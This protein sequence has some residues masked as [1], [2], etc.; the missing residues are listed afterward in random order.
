MNRARGG[1]GAVKKACMEEVGEDG[2]VVYSMRVTVTS[3]QF[4]T[5]EVASSSVTLRLR[6]EGGVEEVEEV[7]ATVTLPGPRAM[8]EVRLRRKRG[9][10]GAL[11]EAKRS[12]EED[13]GRH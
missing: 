7:E 13:E 4:V 10:V 12:R 2:Q 5:Q 11:G 3:R 9:R 1:Q 8:E 6:P